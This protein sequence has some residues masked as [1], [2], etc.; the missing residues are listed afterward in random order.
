MLTSFHCI[1]GI[2][3]FSVALRGVLSSSYRRWYRGRSLLKGSTGQ[4]SY[5]HSLCSYD[6]QSPS[7][8]GHCFPALFS[9]FP[10]NSMGMAGLE[11][12]LHHGGPEEDVYHTV[13]DD[14]AF[15]VDL[16]N[17]PPVPVPRPEAGAPGTHHLPDNE[18]YISKGKCG[19][20]WWSAGSSGLLDKNSPHPLSFWTTALRLCLSE[21]SL[22]SPRRWG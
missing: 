8:F 3:V 14:E 2:S 13:D 5:G 22:T 18:P 21:W 4:I 7:L 19:R 15:T 9:V 10:G 20:E 12:E 11:Q 16:A 1:D 17:R 6:C